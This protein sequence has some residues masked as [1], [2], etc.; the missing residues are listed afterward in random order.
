MLDRLRALAIPPAWTSPTGHLQATGRD[1]RG[2]KQYRYHPDWRRVRD[3]AKFDRMVAFGDALPRIRRRV[4]RDLRGRRLT[5]DRVLAAVV[6]ILDETGMR[7]GN[8]E[9]AHEN[10]SYGATT[11]RDRHADVRGDRVTFRFRGKSGRAHV[12][13]L[14][15]PRVA[16]VVRGCADLPGQ[17]LFQ[18][19][20]DDGEP[21]DVA[22]DHVNGYLRSAGGEE[23]TSKD[24]RTWTGTV[25]AAWALCRRDDGATSMQARRRQVA[26]AV[27]VVADELGNTPAVCRRCYVHPDVIESHL[28]GGLAP[29]LARA[30]RRGRIRGLSS[31]EAAVL[32]VL[33]SGTR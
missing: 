17:V 26:A 32:R 11:L 9:Y 33:K 8:D 7:V 12:L 16:R 4:S 29:A 19:V 10:R 22:S 27:D 3:E 2:R 18:F 6:R 25:V 30:P 1:A 23:L 21:V 15:D 5:K 31:H 20:D 13:E 14:C 24:F 28:D